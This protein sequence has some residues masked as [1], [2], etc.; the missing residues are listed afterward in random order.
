MDKSKLN[1]GP[2]A[3]DITTSVTRPEGAGLRYEDLSYEAQY[4]A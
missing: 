4:Q 3:G 1:L 2:N